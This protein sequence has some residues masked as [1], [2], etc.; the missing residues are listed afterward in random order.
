MSLVWTMKLGTTDKMVLLALADCANDEGIGWPPIGGEKG[1]TS[2]TSLSERAVQKSIQSLCAAGHLTRV[3]KLGKGVLYTVHPR[4][5]CAPTPAQD[6]P[7]H[8]VRPAPR[9]PTPAPRAPKP[10]ITSNTSEA[11]ASSVKRA[12]RIPE[13]WSPA[14]L[15]GV[16]AKIVAGW[17]PGKFDREIEGFRNHH[18]AKGTKMLDWNAA[19]RTWIGNTEKWPDRPKPKLN[20]WAFSA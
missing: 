9:A 8:D 17:P 14:D 13:D 15:T 4:T 1:L 2:K 12:R 11:K 5:T 19:W 16:S 10:S 18:T 6:A 7:P 3:E 20:E